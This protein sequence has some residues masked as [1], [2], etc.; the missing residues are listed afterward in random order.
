MLPVT[1]GADL[2]PPL[3]SAAVGES[4]IA[5]ADS[6]GRR[7]LLITP[8]AAG[9]DVAA[10]LDRTGTGILSIILAD[11]A[12]KFVAPDP[13]A[14]TGAA[15]LVPP[16][17]QGHRYLHRPNGTRN[18]LRHRPPRVQTSPPLVSLRQR[19]HQPLSLMSQREQRYRRYHRPPLVQTLLLPFSLRQR[20][21]LPLSPR[22]QRGNNYCRCPSTAAGEEV[23][24]SLVP[25]TATV[26]TVIPGRSRGRKSPPVLSA[27]ACSDVVSF[28][29]PTAAQGHRPSSSSTQRGKHLRRCSRPPKVPTSSLFLPPPTHRGYLY[30]RCHRP[31]E[32]KRRRFPRPEGSGGLVRCLRQLRG[33]NT[34]ADSTGHQRQPGVVIV[35]TVHTGDNTIVD[36]TRPQQVQSRHSCRPGGSGGR[37]SCRLIVE[38]TAADSTGRRR[39]RRRLSY[40]LHGSGGSGRCRCS[41]ADADVYC[42]CRRSLR[43]RGDITTADATGHDRCR[44]RL[45]WAP[46]QRGQQA[47]FPPTRRRITL[48]SMPPATEG[49]DVAAHLVPAAAKAPAVLSADSAG[50]ILSWPPQSLASLSSSRQRGHWSLSPSTQRGQHYRRFD[51]R[52]SPS[53]GGSGDTNCGHRRPIGDNTIADATGHHRCRRCRSSCSCGSELAGRCPHQLN[54]D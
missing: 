39:C 46:R 19:G 52:C 40:H 6:A 5:Y 15:S 4:I 35:V 3:V 24:A 9:A 7:L 1:T 36:T 23:A 43:L 29:V 42:R 32:V 25:A 21:S 41:T 13:T 2:A 12:W 10:S 8:T 30:H 16:L 44:R 14:A 51:H 34:T 11:S 22:N 31:P 17:Q 26:S 37:Y 18:R 48:P 45:L 33:E 50:K 54:A 28:L 47:L 38:R 49:A 27:A 53:P 20:E